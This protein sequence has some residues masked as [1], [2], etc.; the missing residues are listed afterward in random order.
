MIKV[1]FSYRII[2][3]QLYEA[4][5]VKNQASASPQ[6]MLA[7]LEQKGWLNSDKIV[8]DLKRMKVD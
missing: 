1:R 6:T 4:W 3:Q 7:F 5:C 8:D 2:I